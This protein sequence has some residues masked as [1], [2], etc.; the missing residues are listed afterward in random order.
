L[1]LYPSHLFLGNYK[2]NKQD[3]V[4]KKRAV[5]GNNKKLSVGELTEIKTQ[6]LNGVRPIDL[7]NK[8]Y[9]HIDYSHLCKVMRDF[10]GGKY[11]GI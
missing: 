4:K 5:F 3:S 9:K 2:D 8:K 6:T 7:Y 1:E 10:R 11:L